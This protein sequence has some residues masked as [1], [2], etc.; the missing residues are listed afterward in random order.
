MGLSRYAITNI[1]NGRAEVTDY[2]SRFFCLLHSVNPAWLDS[3]EGNMLNKA[4]HNSREA[5]RLFEALSPPLQEY[6]LKQIQ[7]ILEYQRK[8]GIG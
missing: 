4:S 1:E 6:A 2:F 5:L 3:G 7:L 8:Q